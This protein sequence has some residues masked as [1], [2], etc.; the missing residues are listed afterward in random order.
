[1]GKPLSYHEHKLIIFN[2]KLSVIL[3][4][5]KDGEG[6]GMKRTT[7]ISTDAKSYI[8]GKRL[9]SYGQCYTYAKLNT[10]RTFKAL[11]KLFLSCLIFFPLLSGCILQGKKPNTA[12]SVRIVSPQDTEVFV[13]ATLKISIEANDAEE[14]LS[15]IL[16]YENGKAL[17]NALQT[18]DA[19]TTQDPALTESWYFNWTAPQNG[20]Y[21]LSAEA[22]DQL[23][24]KSMSSVTIEIQVPNSEPPT[25]PGTTLAYNSF[26]ENRILWQSHAI[27]DY[28]V[29]F[30]RICFCLPEI[31]QAATLSIVN[32]VLDDAN[33]LN[34]TTVNQNNYSHFLTINQAFALIEAAFTQ[35][36]A[37]IR[38]DYDPTYGF[39]TSAFVDYDKRIADEELQFRFS[40]FVND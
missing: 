30:Q 16:L 26:L 1:M 4:L 35:S 6:L 11:P 21:T 8:F 34:G 38:V 10:F 23:G 40:N 24:L 33:Y 27:S 29:D 9:K 17:G 5:G 14:N 37:E 36:A 22:I 28:E 25:Q 19:G 7:F 39:P 31:T 2:D 3:H 13:A 20:S 15:S 12:P 18:L 32:Q